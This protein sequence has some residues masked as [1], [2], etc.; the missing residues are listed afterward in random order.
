M[1]Q[2]ESFWEK[3]LIPLVKIHETLDRSQTVERTYG[4]CTAD[5][6]GKSDSDLVLERIFDQSD[7]LVPSNTSLVRS[8]GIG[9]I[10]FFFFFFF[11]V[12]AKLA[13]SSSC[14]KVAPRSLALP[15]IL[16]ARRTWRGNGFA[17]WIG[18]FWRKGKMQNKRLK[19]VEISFPIVYGT[20]SFWLGKKAS[21][22]RQVR[23]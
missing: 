11:I 2:I 20:I 18:C 4:D 15:K 21:E 10:F 23:I 16:T 19:D 6:E 22:R 1:W 3:S 17:W 5:H 8:P 9:N 12:D 14:P 7:P 13:R